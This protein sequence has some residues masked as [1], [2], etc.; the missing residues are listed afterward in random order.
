MI[1]LLAAIEN[2]ER[3]AKKENT[4][5]KWHFY[6]EY[7]IILNRRKRITRVTTNAEGIVE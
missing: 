2:Q 4:T 3:E 7:P 6:D 1:R 5:E